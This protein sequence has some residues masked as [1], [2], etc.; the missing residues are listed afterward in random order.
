MIDRF[1]ECIDFS[2]MSGTHDSITELTTPLNA[3]QTFH[4]TNDKYH[5]SKQTPS[6]QITFCDRRSPL[7][8]SR[9]EIRS[10]GLLI[11]P[12]SPQSS[13]LPR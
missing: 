3:L 5:F 12:T 4:W 8:R 2:H 9:P 1:S 6:D 11:T 7:P 13:R 10:N